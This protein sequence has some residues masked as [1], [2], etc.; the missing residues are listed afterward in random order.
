MTSKVKNKKRETREFVSWSDEDIEVYRAQTEDISEGD[1]ER[2][3]VERLWNKIKEVFGK[4]VVKKE[5][6]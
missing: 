2:N 5:I 4:A 3:S 1:G 6:P